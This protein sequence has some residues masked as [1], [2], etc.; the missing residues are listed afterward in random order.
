MKCPYK[1][2]RLGSVYGGW[3]FIDYPQLNNSAIISVGV[4]EDISFDVEFSKKFRSRVVLIDPTPRAILHFDKTKLNLGQEKRVQYIEGGN[5]PIESYDLE[6]MDHNCL[7]LIKKALWVNNLG[8]NFF[9]PK[10]KNYVSHS[11]ISEALNP[12]VDSISISVPSIT[13]REVLIEQ[14]LRSNFELLKL[15]IEFAGGDVI[16]NMLSDQ[17]YPQQILVE[18][19]E[20]AT[21]DG[22]RFVEAHKSLLSA[23]Y[24]LAN[25]EENV[26]YLYSRLNK[27]V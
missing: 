16:L 21:G 18:F 22:L 27:Y 1:L 9:E 6:G 10:N 3:T 24:L 12:N 26:N 7:T 4:G 17:I 13:L 11:I 19:E 2:T 5:Q 15:D 14:G 23:G 25:V 20:A 8:V